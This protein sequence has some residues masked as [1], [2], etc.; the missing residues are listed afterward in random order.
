MV[1]FLMEP[2]SGQADEFVP[3]IQVFPFPAVF[4]YFGTLCKAWY[5][6]NGAQITD[7]I[8]LAENGIGKRNDPTQEKENTALLKK[9]GYDQET[10]VDFYMELA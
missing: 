5:R 10:L 2:G 7:A 4:R 9:A 3:V 1:F 8:E 6:R